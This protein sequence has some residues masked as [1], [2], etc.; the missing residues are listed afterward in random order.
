MTDK[1]NIAEC[2]FD[3][4]KW[5]EHT[6]LLRNM[7][8][9]IARIEDKLDKHQE[10]IDNLKSDRD[11]RRGANTT[12]KLVAGGG[13]IVGLIGGIVAWIRSL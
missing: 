3:Q 1:C 4:Q 13:G 8:K 2:P 11:E 7:E 12:L 9:G 10:E 6:A 5:G